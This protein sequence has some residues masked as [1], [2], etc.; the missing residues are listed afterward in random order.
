MLLRWIFAIVCSA[1]LYFGAMFASAREASDSLSA[2]TLLVADEKLG[3]PNFA[4]TVVLITR[5]DEEEGTM[6]VVLNHP[7][8]VTLAKAFPQLKGSTDPVYEG[9]PVSPEAVQA[10]LRTS[11]KPEEA[12]HV[13]SDIYAIVRKADLE[14]SIGNHVSSAKFRVYL[15]YAGWGPGQLENEVRMGAWTPLRGAKYVFDSEPASLWDRLDRET[16]SVV[17]RNQSPFPSFNSI[18]LLAAAPAGR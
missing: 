8:D 7:M 13:L 9:G 2:G 6:G 16:H 18:V 10:L 3:D 12:E 14:K 15:G 1:L 17:A 5:R 4:K 11:D